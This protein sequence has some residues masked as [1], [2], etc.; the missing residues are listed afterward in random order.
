M[1][2]VKDACKFVVLQTGFGHVDGGWGKELFSRRKY[3]AGTAYIQ[4]IL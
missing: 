4:L 3:D 1:H 2:K